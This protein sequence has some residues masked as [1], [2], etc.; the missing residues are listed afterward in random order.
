[1]LAITACYCR[2]IIISLGCH[3]TS[4][5]SYNDD[6]DWWSDD[7]DTSV[8]SSA[9][10]DIA[11]PAEH[12][13]AEEALSTLVELL[14]HQSAATLEA[15]TSALQQQQEVEAG[16]VQA[17]DAADDSLPA[18]AIFGVS[19]T[20]PVPGDEANISKPDSGNFST[21]VGRLADALLR[22]L[23][24]AARTPVPH[25]LSRYAGGP[26]G[27][28]WLVGCACLALVG[29][30]LAAVG[31]ISLARSRREREEA[32][33]AEDEYHHLPGVAQVPAVSAA[34][35]ASAWDRHVEA[36][37]AKEA[38]T[39]LK[40]SGSNPIPKKVSNLPA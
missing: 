22:P 1:M 8:G 25:Q 2:A 36:I 27:I 28:A 10:T 12:S 5:C 19:K 14:A 11:L 35:A 4:A 24:S 23:A 33:L 13:Q 34:A 15:L 7:A 3:F 20:A 21:T 40:S 30:L 31:L 39:A 32:A 9:S 29:L 37:K 17:A 16:G 6:D 18:F 26:L 38:A